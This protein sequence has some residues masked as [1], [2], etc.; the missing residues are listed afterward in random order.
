[1]DP[2]FKVKEASNNKLI[3]KSLSNTIEKKMKNVK[4]GI[5]QVE[6]AS[7][8]KYPPYYIEPQLFVA[9]DQQEFSDIGVLYAR[10]VPIEFSSKLEIWIQISAPLIA[11]G[12][13][14][15]VRAVLAHEFLHYV[16][17]SRRFMEFDISSNE[18]HTSLLEASHRDQESLI[19]P[20]RIFSDKKLIKLVN[21]KLPNG[22]ID[23]KL[24]NNTAKKWLDKNL[25]H[26][27]ISTQENA[28]NISASIIP[29][30]NFDPKLKS[31]L[32][33]IERS[34]LKIA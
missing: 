20:A 4:D 13:K 11:F 2:L 18:M 34:S 3:P 33:E 24:Q 17:L 28:V 29:S 6:K 26:V 5:N 21:K 15:T 30:F 25:P 14:T 7:G 12:V 22:L 27:N 31:R 16:E 19:P 10:T 1:M 23:E 32:K 8:L 9:E